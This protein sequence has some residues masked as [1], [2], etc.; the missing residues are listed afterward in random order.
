MKKGSFPRSV[1][2]GS[3][4]G[5]AVV[6][7]V[8]CLAHSS[9]KQYENI[10]VLQTQEQLLMSARSI[11]VGIEEFITEHLQVLRTV[12]INPMIQEQAYKGILVKKPPTGHCPC[13]ALYDAH[14]GHVD[15]FTM[16]DAKGVLLRRIPHWEEKI[17]TDYTDKPG[18]AYVLREHKTHVSEV[19]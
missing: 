18:V 17:G 11:A 15:A 8:V 13:Q 4:V 1:L 19:F 14:A 9:H 7:V 12:S 6:V 5:L 2:L 3:I 10:V 16:L